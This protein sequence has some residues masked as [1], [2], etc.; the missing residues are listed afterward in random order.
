M[1]EKSSKTVSKVTTKVTSKVAIDARLVLPKMRG[2]GRYTLNLLLGLSQRASKLEFTVFYNS[3]DTPKIVQNLGGPYVS[4]FQWVRVRS[5]IQSPLQ[6]AEIYALMRL[7][8]VRAL[9]DTLGLGLYSGK[10]PKITTLHEGFLKKNNSKKRERDFWICVSKTLASQAIERLKINEDRLRVIYNAI[11]PSYLE[12]A[13][14]QEVKMAKERF[15]IKTPYMLCL[16]NRNKPS[17]N[18]KLPYETSQWHFKKGI[19]NLTWVFVTDGITEDNRIFVGEVEDL[20]LKALYRGA[21]A[22]VVPSFEDGFSLP[23]IEALSQHTLAL[24]SGIPVHAELFDGVIPKE[25]FFDPFLE[26]EKAIEDLDR[27]ILQVLL[28]KEIY[29]KGILDTFLNK[30][31]LFSYVETADQVQSVYRELLNV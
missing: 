13:Q 29:K 5:G 6:N 2:T 17:K 21:E 31:E 7:H 8:R 25:F 3:P 9:H 18:F 27:A 26:K 16:A 28:N 30:K 12:F 23:P 22:V 4:R 24:L 15:G 14:D 1:E 19:Q 10:I 20:W 11:P